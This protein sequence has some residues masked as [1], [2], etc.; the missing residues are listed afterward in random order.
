MVKDGMEMELRVE[1]AEF[2]YEKGRT[3]FRG[4]EF[5]VR[6]PEIF[7]ILGVNG[8]GKSTLLKSM[9][10]FLPLNAGRVLCN[11]KDIVLFSRR[12]MGRMLA[13]LPQSHAPL[14]SFSALEVAL[15]GR[16]AHLP[17]MGVPGAKDR[18]KALAALEFLGIGHLAARNITELSGGERQLVMLAAALAQ[19][20]CMM[21]LDE[22]VSHLDYGHQYRFL[23]ILKKLAASGV[24]IVM[25]T[26]F[27]DHALLVGDR[28]AI[29][30]RDGMEA[31]GRPEE[32][33]TGE[34]MSALYGIPVLVRRTPEGYTCRVHLEGGENE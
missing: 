1:G 31:S 4:V 23:G 18:E 22:P 20:P 29:L 5:V 15:M 3:V 19:E 24:G 6:S 7:C 30:G 2:A 13:Y 14:F 11:G 27:P 28:V 10:G 34:R 33:I 8:A 21:L 9:A 26:H 17:Y 16:T 25:T 32:I 12:E